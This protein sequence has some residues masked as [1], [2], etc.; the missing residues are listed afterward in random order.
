M[1]AFIPMPDVEPS[2]VLVSSGSRNKFYAS[3]AKINTV[4]P[5]L[6]AE[7]IEVL[8]NTE[9]RFKEVLV[10]KTNPLLQSE[11][12]KNA[13]E[14]MKVLSENMGKLVEVLKKES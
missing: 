7:V 3:G 9:T 8:S 10:L 4:L 6:V 14:Y 11:R 1:E 2:G 13:M 12:E 5:A